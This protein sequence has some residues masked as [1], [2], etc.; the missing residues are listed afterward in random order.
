MKGAWSRRA[1]RRS[2]VDPTSSFSSRRLF[3]YVSFIIYFSPPNA[4]AFALAS[5]FPFF[6]VACCF[7]S[8]S[9]VPHHIDNSLVPLLVQASLVNCA[10]ALILLLSCKAVS[11][12][13]SVSFSLL[14][15]FYSPLEI[16]GAISARVSECISS[17]LFG[18]IIPHFSHVQFDIVNQCS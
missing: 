6:S 10:A 15:F 13:R 3:P 4:R 14:C 18:S 8:L 2:P 1:H 5:S 12:T 7:L 16:Y 17:Q 9:R 11:E